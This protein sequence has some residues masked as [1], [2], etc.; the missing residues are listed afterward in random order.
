MEPLCYKMLFKRSVYCYLLRLYATSK[1]GCL[2]S[3]SFYLPI[4]RF[5][6]LSSL[7]RRQFHDTLIK[8]CDYEILVE[9]RETRKN[10]RASMTNI[11]RETCFEI[12]S[13]I[14]IISV[15]FE[16]NLK[17]YAKVACL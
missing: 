9:L 13:I 11:L 4:C 6:A 15:K 2:E 16:T 17:T 12:S 3:N 7:H 8:T 10:I 1:T 5:F 14:T